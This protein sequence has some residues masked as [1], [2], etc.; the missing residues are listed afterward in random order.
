MKECDAPKSNS[1]TAEVMI[2]SPTGIVLLGSHR[3]RVGSMGSGRCSYSGLIGT[4]VQIGASVDVMSLFT[5]IVAP[6]IT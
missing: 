2:D 3:S 4:S 1:T 6:T 5:I